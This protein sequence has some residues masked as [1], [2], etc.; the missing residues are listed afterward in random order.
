VLTALGEEETEARAEVYF[1]LGLV[2]QNQGQAKQAINNFEKALAL[3][4]SHRSTLDA[5]VAV[6]ESLKDWKQVCAYRRQILDNVVEGGERF[7]MLNQIGD[8][9]VDKENNVE[10]GIEAL[11]EALDLEPQDHVL[12]HKLLQ[13]YQKA[14]QWDRMVDCLQ[15]I[16]DLEMQPERKSR[17]LYTMAQLYRDKLDDQLRAVD[18]FN[19]ALDLNPNFLEAFERINKILTALKEWKQL[20]RAYRKMLHRVAGKGN[21]DLEYSLWHAL[22]LIYR[23]RLGD[24][25][26]SVETFRMASRLK[27]DN[28]DEHLILAELHEQLEQPD[29]AIVEFQAMLKLDPMKVDP[30]RRLYRLYLDKKAYDPAWCLAAALAFLRKADEEEQRFFEDYRPQGMI[31][32]KSRLDNEQW[33]RNLFHE[34]E[35]L[36]VGK[37]FEMIASAALKA[38]IEQLKVKKEVP[39]LDP[40]FRQDPATSTVTFARTFGWAAQVL[41]VPAPLLYVRS[42]VPGSLVAVANEQPASVA[43]QTVLTGFTP[44]D[45]TFIVGKHLAMYRGEH[46]IKTLFPTV[47]ELT[48]MLF[49]GIKLVAPETPAPADI[50]K[51][52]M[53]TAA[54]LRQYIQPMQLEGLRMVVKKFLAEGAKAN[55]K[56]WIQCVEITAARTGLLLCGDLEIAKK[57]I[58]AEPQQPGDL[59]AQEKLKELI[60]FSISDQYFALRQS[61][62]INIGAE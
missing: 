37:I 62:G 36:Y 13:L 39:V 28:L 18:L 40:R 31:Q 34:D 41:A 43:G 48:V 11:E 55:I 6:Y 32:V 22:G 30:Y 42:D 51:H 26:A 9:W 21:N 20:E 52:I 33:I 5:M 47:T 56:R 15:R 45:L 54:T 8:I 14:N 2:K 19:E 59:T 16:A 53:A 3:E 7:K 60:L 49:A 50:E 25:N 38:K 4:P 1:K 12:L 61:L 29:D 46:Y 24:K 27:P 44:Q 10:K 58:A 23:D 35:N 17:Y 57:I